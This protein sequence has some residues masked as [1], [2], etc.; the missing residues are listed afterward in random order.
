MQS[1]SLNTDQC[2]ALL[3]IDTDHALVIID[4]FT[5]ASANLARE[6]CLLHELG[7]D[8]TLIAFYRV[9]VHRSLC[10][11]FRAERGW[12]KYSPSG[13]LLDR[14]VRYSRQPA[15]ETLQ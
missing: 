11:P 3:T 5:R 15:T 7:D 6:S 14:E 2:R 8:Q 4:Q 10:H 1:A 13:K 12:E 9:W